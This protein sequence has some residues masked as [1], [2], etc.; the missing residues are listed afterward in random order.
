M[1]TLQKLADN[2]LT[3]SQ[4][5]TTALCS[6]TRSCL[7]TGR[8][9]HVNPVR[10]HHR[11]FRQVPGCGSTPACPRNARRWDRCWEQRVQH[12][13]VGKDHNVPEEDVSSGSSKSE[14]P[15]QK[16]LRPVL[17]IPGR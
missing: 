5:H 7:L 2:G 11:G 3:Y 15:L 13:W 14:W 10:E 4:W 1:P 9:H 8:N 6:P 16:G 12:L 17:R